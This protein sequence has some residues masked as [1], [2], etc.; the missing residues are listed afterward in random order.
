MVW[1]VGD[2]TA[3]VEAAVKLAREFP[4]GE[5]RLLENAGH[6]PQEEVPDDLVEQIRPFLKSTEG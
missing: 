3:P 2:R 5:I 6:M 1:G 4:H